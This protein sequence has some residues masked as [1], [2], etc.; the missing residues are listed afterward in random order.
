MSDRPYAI[1]RTLSSI[2]LV[3]CLLLFILRTW[4]WPLMGDAA[5]MHYVVFLMDHGMAP[6]RDIVDP[7]MPTTLLIEGTVMH[8]FGG[9][10]LPWRL[11]DLSLLAVSGIAMFVISKPYSRFAA[12]FAASLFTLI[13]GRDGLVELGQRDLT[14]TV[15]LLI[16][17]AF[18]LTGL[19]THH[20][21]LPPKKTRPWM[22]ATFGFF[23]GVA[24][25]IKPSVLFLAPAVLLLAAIALKRRQQPFVSHLIAGLLGMLTPILLILAWLQH[26]HITADF[27]RTLTQLLPYFLLLGPRSYPHL[28]LH[29]ISSVMLPIVLL[30]LPIV[31]LKKDWITWE[32]AALLVA[33]LFGLASFYLQ[34]KGFPYHRYP[35]EAFLL[36]L[37]A[38]DFTTILKTRPAHWRLRFTTNNKLLPALAITGIVVGVVFVAGGST[39]HAL[40]QDWRN[41]EFDTMLRADLNRLGGEKLDNRVQCLDMADGCIP[42]L[43]NMR[44]VQSTGYL[45]DCYMLSNQ[46]GAEQDRSREAFWHAIMKNPPAVFVVS[47]NDCDPATQRPGYTYQKMSRWPQFDDYLQANYHLDV[48]RIPPHMVNAGSSPSKPLGYRIYTKNN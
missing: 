26:Q 23:C 21:A 3:V 47:S 12:L 39:A 11:F 31:L 17:Y 20:R 7:N 19:R 14:M 40:W 13:H 18:L 30:W 48:E 45:Y 34:R 41:Q 35:S 37:I 8:L 1:T 25:T 43:Y 32:R 42:T 27:F 9:N 29:S 44:L 6:Y 10:S 4:H 33:V 5:L 16:G 15:C 28:V 24:A 36:L 38:I 22:T 46:P 2:F